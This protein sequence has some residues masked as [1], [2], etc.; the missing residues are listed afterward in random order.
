MEDDITMA[1]AAA[2]Q[3]AKAAGKDSSKKSND[4]KRKLQ[5]G[6]ANSLPKGKMER[7]I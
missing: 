2:R 6:V 4:K 7:T 3:E 1:K 5:N